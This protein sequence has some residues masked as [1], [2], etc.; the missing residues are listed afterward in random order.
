MFN[1]RVALTEQHG[2]ALEVAQ[3][4]PEGVNYSF[5]QPLKFGHKFLKSPI[6]GFFSRF[7]SKEHDIIEAIL[8]PI[9]TN[10][11]WIYSL[12]NFHEAVAFNFLGIPLPRIVRAFFMK[13]IF[14]KNNFKKLIF[15]S[16]AGRETLR[17]YPIIFD[18]T[19]Q[20]KIE[21]VYPAIRKVPDSLQSLNKKKNTNIFLLFSGDFFRKGGV[22]VIDA[23]EIIQKNFSNV[24]LI[25]CCDEKIDFNTP[26]VGLKEK[27]L[28]K[29]RTNNAIIFLGRV[30]RNKFLREILPKNIYLLPTYYEAFGFAVLEA[31]AYGIPVI[32]TNLSAIPEMIEHGIS[33]FL[34]DVKNFNIEKMFKGYV[35]KNIPNRF[36]K[37]VTQMLLYFL[38]CL[39]SNEC[40]RRSFGERALET[41]KKKF[42]F[43]VRNKK[44]LEI[45]REALG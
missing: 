1:I 29:I 45:Y 14:E 33:G 5:I 10:N 22:N 32:S 9:R 40:L 16:F 37:Y 2:M 26:N 23:F 20:Q 3:F 21:I 17:D 42:S 12:A 13:K 4:P 44:M 8:S 35:V 38:N 19:L 18:D 15:W 39:L 41:V 30:S 6:K 31:M 34:I 7:E 28:K 24:K 36:N 27:Y 43:E 25:L 11:K